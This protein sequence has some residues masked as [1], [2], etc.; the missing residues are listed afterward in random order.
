MQRWLGSAALVFVLAGCTQQKT[1]W[2]RS[3]GQPMQDSPGLSE[4]YELDRKICDGQVQTAN[5]SGS[6]V[7]G[8]T[9]ECTTSA[10]DRGLALRDAGK[11]CMADRGY[12]QVPVEEAG[13]RAAISQPQQSRA[14]TVSP[15][16]AVGAEAPK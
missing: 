6:S 16:N 10:V 5:L 14:T 15:G 11:R 12:M 8:S 7:C 9:A 2:V 13:G 4:R 1:V 3:D